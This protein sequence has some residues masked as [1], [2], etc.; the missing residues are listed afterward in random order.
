MEGQYVEDAQAGGV[1]VTSSFEGREGT[2]VDVFDICH[3][4][5]AVSSHSHPLQS[6]K[7]VTSTVFEESR[8]YGNPSKSKS[9][10]NLSALTV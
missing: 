8:T 9:Q 1:D 6:N 10:K 2:S 7:G 5:L 3:L 4:Q